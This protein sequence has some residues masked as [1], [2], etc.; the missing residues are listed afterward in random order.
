LSELERFCGRNLPPNQLDNNARTDPLATW[1][2]LGH[3]D[4]L[5]TIHNAIEWKESDHVH[6]SKPSS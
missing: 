3:W 5:E 6:P 4:V 1:R 2:K